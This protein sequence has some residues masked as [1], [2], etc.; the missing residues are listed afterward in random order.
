VRTVTHKVT[1]AVVGSILLATAG[2]AFGAW[3]V[4]QRTED[5]LLDR[6]TQQARGVLTTAVTSVQTP[7]SIAAA[8]AARGG[9]EAFRTAI[10]PLVGDDDGQ[11][12][13]AALLS[14][15]GEVL[16]SLGRALRL[17]TGGPDAA[18]AFARR[19]FGNPGMSVIG[20]LDG[21][22]ASI[23]FGVSDTATPPGVVAYLE[24][25]LPEQRTSVRSDDPA[26]D[27]VH[28]ALYLTPNERRAGMI[29]SSTPDLPLDGNRAAVTVPFGDRQLLLVFQARENLGGW[30]SANLWWIIAIV[31]LLVA[32]AAGI[33]TGALASSRARA[34]DV[35]SESMQL[36]HEQLQI[37]VTL[38]RSLLPHAMPALAGIGIAARY[39]PATTHAEVGGDWYD[40][41][42]LGRRGLVVMVGDVSGHGIAAAT[43]MAALRYAA[44]AYA[45]DG[46]RPADLL[47]RLNRL[48]ETDREGAFATALCVSLDLE[49]ARVVVANAGHPSPILATD[50]DVRVLT[51]RPGPPI[52]VVPAPIYETAEFDIP[53]A[54]TIVLFTDGLFERRGEGLDDGLLRIRR[55]VESARGPV[56]QMV[57]R[58][59]ELSIPDEHPD[60]VVLLGVQWNG[61]GMSSGAAVDHRRA[62]GAG[63]GARGHTMR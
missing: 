53:D 24:S 19:A 34:E 60:D 2:L 44:R 28:Y 23:G 56:D 31:G 13:S 17:T 11:F 25:R 30:L 51:T 42:D 36:Y 21:P 7:L 29:Y 55:I 5:D 39:E 6:Q 59:V 26:Y 57:R 27:N 43:T 20:L 4:H 50:D 45:I 61:T 15:T 9:P 37:A 12:A 16:T 48:V 58:T 63:S 32:G 46:V 22:D 8:D 41:I 18:R 33:V 38:Q 62:L 35:A 40:V 10:A 54:A 14:P 47:Q 49:N 1:V 3:L 52:G